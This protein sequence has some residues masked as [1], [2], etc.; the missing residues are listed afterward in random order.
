MSSPA[1]LRNW[2]WIVPEVLGGRAAKN[3]NIDWARS[4][5]AMHDTLRNIGMV[6]DPPK[7]GVP[8][9]IRAN[10][11]GAIEDVNARELFLKAPGTPGESKL[12]LVILPVKE[13]DLYNHI[14]RVGDLQTGVHT[15]CVQGKKFSN[16]TDIQYMANVAMKFNIKM[17]GNN[18]LLQT[19]KLGVLGEGKTMVVGLDVT[20]PEPG[21]CS[22]APSIAG[23]AQSVPSQVAYSDDAQG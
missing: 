4:A 8:L 23:I 12:L 6:A 11:Q 16:P 7:T 17:G 2:T 9:R 21:S 13:T 14:K 20:H 10:E 19:P 15:V 18:Q 22:N 1:T 3:P 5:K